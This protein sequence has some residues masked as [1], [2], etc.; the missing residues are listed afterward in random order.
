DLEGHLKGDGEEEEEKATK[1]KSK[2]KRTKKVKLDEDG[3]EKDDGKEDLQ[4]DRALEYLKSWDG[5]K[6]KRKRAS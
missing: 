1:K 2:H 3:F 6:G 5:Y 4:L